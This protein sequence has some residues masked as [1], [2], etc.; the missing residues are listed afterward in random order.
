[1]ISLFLHVGLLLEAQPVNRI[2][3]ENDG[4]TILLGSATVDRLRQSPFDAW[5]AKNYQ[6]DDY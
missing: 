5:F 4:D 6:L 2:F 3:V 1:M